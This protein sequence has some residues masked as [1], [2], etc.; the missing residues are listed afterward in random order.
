MK[1]LLFV[2]L[3]ACSPSATAEADYTTRLLRCV[4]K[5]ETLAESKAC[6]LAVDAQLGVKDGGR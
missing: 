2:T 1:T 3:V 6:R 5:S 4:D